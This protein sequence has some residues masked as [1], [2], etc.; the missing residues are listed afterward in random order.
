[1]AVLLCC[2]AAMP[3]ARA[4]EAR[5][6]AAPAAAVRSV[7]PVGHTVGVKLFS[8]GL[9]V[10][11]VS[12]STGSGGESC[13]ARACGLQTGDLLLEMNR[14]TLRSTEQLQEALQENGAKSV[15]LTVKRGARR[16]SL[17]TT[18]VSDSDGV[19]RLGAW[20][21]DSMAGIGTMTYYDP[22][23]GTFG[24]LG[25]GI[26]DVDTAQLM[27]ISSGSLM[28]SAVC[29][30][31]KGGGGKPGE[32]VGEFETTAELGTLQCNSGCGIFGKLSDTS[33]V[34]GEPVP[35]ARRDEVKCGKATILCNVSGDAVE[36]F[37]IKI[38]KILGDSGNCRDMMIRVDDSRLLSK[39]GG[40]VQGM[41]GSPILQNGRIVG[42]V[43][44]VLVNDPARGY[45]ILMEKMLDAEP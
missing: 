42:A 38:T 30:V 34:T 45:A 8:D 33:L 32:L 11:N 14:E 37:S 18:P 3:T 21:R 28:P 43:T 2:A 9:L 4:A 26:T 1:M 13:P 10:V 20:V 40:I 39:T 17:E 15:S 35:V 27:P 41:S 5:G 29:Q 6:E 36:E 22:L 24:A 23:T 7:I 16:L 12:E 19:Y 44:H 31:R 25:H